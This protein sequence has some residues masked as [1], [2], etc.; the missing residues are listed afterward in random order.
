MSHRI[1]ITFGAGVIGGADAGVSTDD[2][3]Y[4]QQSFDCSP[5]LDPRTC[6]R[7]VTAR[8]R[9]PVPFFRAL[10]GIEVPVITRVVIVGATRA[11]VSAWEDRRNLTSAIAGVRFSFNQ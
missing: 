5:S 10:A 3:E 1:G 9:G 4:S 11:E 2:T 8:V 6:N 7:L